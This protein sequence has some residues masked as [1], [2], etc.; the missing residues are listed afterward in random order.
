MTTGPDAHFNICRWHAHRLYGFAYSL[1]VVVSLHVIAACVKDLA[2]WLRSNR[3]QLNLSR[4]DALSCGLFCGFPSAG[5]IIIHCKHRS[6]SALPAVHRYAFVSCLLPRHLLNSRWRLNWNTVYLLCSAASAAKHSSV[7]Q[8]LPTSQVLSQFNFENVK[9]AGI[10]SFLIPRLQSVM[11]ADARPIVWSSTREHITPV[12]RRPRL[13]MTTIFHEFPKHYPA[14]CA[15]AKST[16]L[17]LLWTY[18]NYTCQS[19]IHSSRV[20]K[21]CNIMPII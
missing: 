20:S 5:I 4:T 21:N 2:K 17:H 11:N 13:H 10:L 1:H 9:L 7:F 8:L 3:L 15:K 19:L 16:I 18:K 14:A 6:R 12:L